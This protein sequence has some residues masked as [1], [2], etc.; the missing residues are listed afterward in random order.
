[1]ANIGDFRLELSGMPEGVPES[2]EREAREAN[3]L[4]ESGKGRGSEFLGW[5]T[6]PGGTTARTLD[7]ISSEAA[8]LRSLADTIVV[9]GI[10]G[11]Y[12]GAKAVIS[13]LSPYFPGDKPS[14]EVV[15][16]GH[17]LSGAYTRQ[18]LEYLR[19]RSFAVIVISK[20]GTTTE[21]A[22]AFRLLRALM[23]EKYGDKGAAQRTVAITDA[24]K[25]ALKSLADREGYRTFA[26]PDDVGGRFSVFTPVGLLP[27]AA[28]GF[29]ISA[30]VCGA[31]EMERRLTEEESPER[32]P[33]IMYAAVRNALYRQG[34]TTEVLTVYEP[35]LSYLSEWWKQLFGES[36]GKEGKGIFPA[37]LVNVTDLHSMGQYMQEG[38][39]RL[40]ETVVFEDATAGG[41]AVSTEEGDP[42]GLDYLAGKPL[43]RINAVAAEGVRMAHIDGGVPNIRIGVPQLD[44]FWLGALLYFFERA[45]AISGYML[46]VN[47]FDQPGVEA[48]KKNMFALLGKP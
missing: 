27:I 4:L 30:L 12:L 15:F 47:P 22:V 26:V 45:C 2:M 41:P 24:H 46:D 32:N 21:S 1:M 6:L 29:D 9:V 43:D 40:F 31:A 35:R 20:S 13:A 25:G 44:E 19:D 11:S 5:L 10:G 17:T 28:A 38:E 23:R 16:A 37:S 14:P 7:E 34:K 36:E 3:R 42:D 33:A 39:R 18:L 48:Y 8:R